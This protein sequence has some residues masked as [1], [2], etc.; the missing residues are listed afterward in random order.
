MA[1][2][3]KYADLKIITE[4]QLQKEPMPKDFWNYTVHPITGFS[5]HLKRHE[6]ISKN[7][8][9]LNK[10]GASNNYTS[11]RVNGSLQRIYNG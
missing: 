6:V 9:D 10:Y 5:T 8:R 3:R 1:N 4:E 7:K 2:K 11:T